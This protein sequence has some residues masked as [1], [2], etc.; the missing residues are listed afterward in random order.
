MNS[1]DEDKESQNSSK[2]NLT[3]NYTEEN[4]PE[5]KTH[6]IFTFTIFF[7]VP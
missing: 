6:L 7:F 4:K 5:P 3:R 2:A 1:I